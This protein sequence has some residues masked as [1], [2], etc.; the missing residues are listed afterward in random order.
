LPRN[1]A[2]TLQIALVANHHHGKVVL[3]LH[4]QNLLL[5]GGDLVEALLGCDGVDKQETF[6]SAHV[7][8]PHS[9]VLLLTSGIENIEQSN[10]IVDHTLLT[11]GI[12]ILVSLVSVLDG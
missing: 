7:L 12:C 10:L 2:L 6:A 5:E 11:V 1:L 4:S 3:V 8:L 9:G